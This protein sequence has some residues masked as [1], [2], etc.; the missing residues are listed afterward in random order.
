MVL[1]ALQPLG[2]EAA[3]K[4]WDES[5]QEQDVKTKT[6]TLRWQKARHEADRLRRQFDA[7]DPASNRFVSGELESRWNGALAEVEQAQKKLEASRT[8]AQP[9]DQAERHR[10]L[11]LGA[12]ICEKHG[13]IQ[14]HRLR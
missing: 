12:G 8:V 4:A 14:P 7:V 3:M 11:Q 2:V 1:D 9:L 6:L 10:L 5:R 13:I